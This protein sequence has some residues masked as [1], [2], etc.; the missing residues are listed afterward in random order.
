[1]KCNYRFGAALALAAA[2]VAALTAC[3][4][5][6]GE[7][8]AATSSAVATA[9]DHGHWT[10]G[11]TPPNS[12]GVDTVAFRG[13]MDAGQPFI[14]GIVAAPG[15]TA[16]CAT[17]LVIPTGSAQG[18]WY[19]NEQGAARGHGAAM[20][21]EMESVGDCSGVTLPGQV[22]DSG[23]GVDTAAQED[24]AKAGVPFIYA[25]PDGPHPACHSAVRLPDGTEW[26]LNV[27]GAAPTAGMALS[28]TANAYG[29][30]SRGAGVDIPRGGN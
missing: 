4:P 23:S 13:A 2:T 17:G 27:S 5:G 25:L 14:Y 1:M 7:Q 30:T 16:I 29:C 9:S 3:D 18:T 6:P 10:P 22:P 11:D 24:S 15:A 20:S 26:V 28:Q 8:A 21:R 19:L 12:T